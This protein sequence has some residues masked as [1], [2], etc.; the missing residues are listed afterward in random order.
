MTIDFKV[1]ELEVL[2]KRLNTT[3]NLLSP[4][5]Q[6]KWH[7]HTT[8]TNPAGAVYPKVKSTINPELLT[9]AWLKFYECLHQFE[10]V[11]SS[12]LSKNSQSFESYHLCEVPGAF[13][14][15]LN[16]FLKTNHPELKVKNISN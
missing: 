14:S 13:I 2:K 4:T 15:A 11:D 8:I 12:L 9:Q 16:H 10:I 3:K 5:N 7:Y 1:P 6:E